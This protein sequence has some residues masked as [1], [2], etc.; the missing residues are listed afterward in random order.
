MT[1]DQIA[2]QVRRGSLVRVRHGVC[3]TCVPDML[4]QLG[5]VDAFLGQQAVACLGTATTLYGFDT[6]STTAIHVLDPA[7]RLRPN[8]GLMVHQ[9]YGA[10][11]THVEGRLATSPAWT[12]VEVA[13]QLGRPRALAT[14]DAALHSGWC[15]AAE[16]A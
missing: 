7:V 12:A 10:P 2:W 16:L 13:R 4:G 6:E 3:A 14:L 1:R 5:A 9:R 8:V 11:L 15:T